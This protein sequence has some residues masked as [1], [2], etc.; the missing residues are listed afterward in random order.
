MF[1][2]KSCLAICLTCNY[3]QLSLPTLELS[4]SSRKGRKYYLI[5]KV[6]VTIKLQV[7]SVGPDT[8]SVCDNWLLWL[9]SFPNK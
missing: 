9:S 3:Q 6:K 1:R 2:F 4:F 8:M 5:Y 7:R